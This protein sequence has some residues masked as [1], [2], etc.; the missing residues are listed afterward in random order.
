M[1][2]I[3]E[4]ASSSV[5]LAGRAPSRTVS[6]A[7]LLIAADCKRLLRH[8][9]KGLFCTASTCL[10]LSARLL[11]GRQQK[12][13]AN[14]GGGLENKEQ[15]VLRGQSEHTQRGDYDAQ[16]RGGHLKTRETRW[17]TAGKGLLPPPPLRRRPREWTLESP[18]HP[19][20]SRKSFVLQASPRPIRR[21]SL[22][23]PFPPRGRAS[24]RRRRHRLQRECPT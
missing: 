3:L 4:A 17:A 12:N 6:H 9:R 7:S 15:S 13:K 8:D 14:M 2:G 18:R 22:T 21:L 19:R 20:Q 1:A 23:S 11:P 5:L 16:R 10:G 24:P